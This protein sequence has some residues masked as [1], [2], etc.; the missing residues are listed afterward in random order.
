MIRIKH[1]SLFL[2][3][4]VFLSPAQAQNEAVIKRI[5][6]RL[7]S[8]FGHHAMERTCLVT[9]KDVYKPGETILFHALAGSMTV[10]GPYSA[11]SGFKLSLYSAAGKVEAE[12]SFGFSSGMTSGSLMIPAN[13]AAGKYVLEAHSPSL[14]NEDE[15]YMKLIFIDPMNEGEVVFDPQKVPELIRAGESHSVVLALRDLAGKAMPDQ[16]LNYELL[17]GKDLLASGKLKTDDKGLLSFELVV[18]EGVY[19]GPV[20]LKVSDS[21]NVNYSRWF[22]VNTEKLKV[23]F[24]AEGGHFVAGIPVKSGFRVTTTDGQPVAVAAEIT[25][26]E[27]R[28]VSQAK[29]LIP[30][31]GMF[32]LIVKAGETCHFRIT[33]ELGKGQTFELPAFEPQGLALSVSRTDSEFI[34]TNL[35][36]PDSQLRE[37]NLLLTRGDRLFWASTVKINGSGRM[38]IPK[39]GVPMGLCLLSAFDDQ[40][41]LL[42]ERLLYIDKPE[43][44]QLS[45][46]AEQ[47]Q[48]GED[49]SWDLLIKAV[50]AAKAD[51][52]KISV[53]VSAAIKNSDA[54]DDFV[55]CFSLNDLLE[56]R[57]AGISGLKKQGIL[58]ENIIDYLLISNRFRNYSWQSV[59]D[60]EA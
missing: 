55:N 38:K 40:G 3:L 10:Q 47:E 58:N 22:H 15:A 21:K 26:D 18:P 45:V 16:K 2:L 54:G 59:L 49:Q 33:S 56:N 48:T 13:L 39:E 41:K 35:V 14:L 9:D 12:E 1:I 6:D 4:S 57:I 11:A 32:P 46:S 52:V 7:I 8:Y 31:Y 28:M 53:S 20:R 17:S 44:L 24:Y 60:F 30:G 42:G 5:H 34:H 50:P 36:F 51:S 29:T 23:C 37:V 27:G 25:G 19:S 43:E